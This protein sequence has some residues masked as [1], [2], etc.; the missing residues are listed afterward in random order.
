[1]NITGTPSQ[2]DNIWAA[3]MVW[4]CTTSYHAGVLGLG[5]PAG[6]KFEGFFLD[7]PHAGYQRLLRH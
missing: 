2:G 1:M 4:C 5:D 7:H 6:D 3:E